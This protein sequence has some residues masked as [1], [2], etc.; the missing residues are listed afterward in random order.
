MPQAALVKS[1]RGVCFRKGR[2]ILPDENQGDEHKR[3]TGAASKARGKVTKPGGN[4]LK[5]IARRFISLIPVVIGVT[6]IVF[7]IMHF[8]PGCPVAIML[9]PEAPAA[10]ADA[11]R[12]RLGLDDPVH[13]QYFRWLSGIIRGDF[14]QSIRGH[15]PVL[16]AIW[17]R[18][19]AT[20]E[21]TVAGMLV[22]LLIAI[23]AGII[24]A[25][26]RNTLL[27][28]TFMVGALFGVSMPV[29]WL[30]LMLMLIFSFYLGWTPISGRGTISHLILP[31][32]TL[33]T[34]QAALVARLT[35]SSMLEVIQ[36]DYITTARSKG[37]REKLV[38]LKHALKNALIPVVTI[39]AL[40]LPVL[41]GGAVITET[42]FAWPGMGRFM[43]LSIFNRD[44][45]VTQGIVLIITILVIMANLLA[46][47]LYAY[48]DPRIRYE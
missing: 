26:K 12:A 13:V 42:V 24:S 44:F 30:G 25:I 17:T 48:L 31:A 9:G 23:P 40:Q 35:R 15:Q 47:I 36:Q 41:F 32:F 10:A 2:E 8:A 21:L 16:D 29:F 34:F 39:V 37:L 38:I 22:S 20:L 6:L 14:G 33:G 5:Y 1:R 4:M 7:S 11:L 43:V 27:D 3:T 28:H 45:P 46:D 19:P 18:L